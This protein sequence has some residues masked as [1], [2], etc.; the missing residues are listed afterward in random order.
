MH[1]NTD[2]PAAFET[3]YSF[4]QDIAIFQPLD[5]NINTQTFTRDH[6]CI[7]HNK[8]VPNR[9]SPRLFSFNTKV[10]ACS[11]CD[12]LGQYQT[13]QW[14]KLFLDPSEGSAWFE[15]RKKIGLANPIIE[16]PT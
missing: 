4:G 10:G 16:M 6:K 2:V 8:V 5:L 11:T 14:N 7:E 1:L 3:A 12:G 15:N 13:V 9:L